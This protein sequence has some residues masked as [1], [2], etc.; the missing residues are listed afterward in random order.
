[1]AF[2]IDDPVPHVHEVGAQLMIDLF[3]FN[4]AIALLFNTYTPWIVIFP[5]LVIGLVFGAIPG[6]QISTA[7]AIFLPITLFMDFVPAMIF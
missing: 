4:K 3:A 6:L 5:G 7:M 1:M 2:R